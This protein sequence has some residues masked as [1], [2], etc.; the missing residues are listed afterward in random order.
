MMPNTD[1]VN[2]KVRCTPVDI[3]FLVRATGQP[4][5]MHARIPIH[6][7]LNVSV[8]KEKLVN[9]CDQQ[10]LQLLEFGFPLDYNRNCTLCRGNHISAT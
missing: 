7:Q 8:W 10:L 3:H 2:E 4:N 9:Y 6:S 1:K 5:F